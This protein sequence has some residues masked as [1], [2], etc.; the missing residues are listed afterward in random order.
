MP[1]QQNKPIPEFI[2]A[3]QPDFIPAEQ[4]I[5]AIDNRNKIQRGFDE[6]AN[7]TP[8][9]EQGKPWLLNKAQEFGAGAIGSLSPLVHPIKTIEGIGNAISHPEE[10]AKSVWADVKEH[11]AQAAGNLVGGLVTGGLASE[12]G[13]PLLARIPTRAK[14][15]ALFEQAMG[16]AENE[17]VWMQ[18]SGPELVRARELMERGGGRSAPVNALLKRVGNV[19]NPPL[20][21]REARD[22]ASN[23]S[24]LSAG[25]TQKLSPVM[26]KQVGNLSRA[27]NQDVGDAATRAGAG[28]EYNQAMQ[29][30]ARAMQLRKALINSAKIGGGALATG[31][32]AHRL[33][34]MVL[35]E[36]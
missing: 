15:G 8:E 17:P 23:L 30:Y 11:P 26:Q 1:P 24:R 3:E 22:Y 36:R 9:Q 4:P 27:F 33:L 10:T 34:P 7:V 29:S 25:E 28:P 35:P 5:P 18:K 12:A 32:L 31:Y 14:A 2:P 21:Y 19:N 6:L 16:K 13:A 20:P